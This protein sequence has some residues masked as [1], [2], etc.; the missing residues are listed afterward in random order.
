MGPPVWFEETECEGDDH[1]AGPMMNFVLAIVIFTALGFIQGVQ[2]N[3]PLI[4]KLLPDGSANE[5]GFKEGDVVLSIDGAEISNFEDITEIVR[6][7]PGEEL[8]F[9]V[10]RGDKTL[11]I[12]VTPKREVAEGKEFGLIEYRRPSINHLQA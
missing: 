12:P 11:D 2:V 6:S 7:H 10:E 3:D 1:F 4:G 8:V 9:T 5:A